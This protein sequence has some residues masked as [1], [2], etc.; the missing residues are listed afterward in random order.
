MEKSENIMYYICRN[1]AINTNKENSGSSAKLHMHAYPYDYHFQ[2][3]IF[4]NDKPLTYFD[5]QNS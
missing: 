3:I 1:L 2:S 4:N 5:M